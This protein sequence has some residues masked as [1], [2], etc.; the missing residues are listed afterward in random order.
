MEPCVGRGDPDAPLLQPR[1]T[2]GQCGT[3]LMERCVKVAAPY[4]VLSNAKEPRKHARLFYANGY[5]V[6]RLYK[7]YSG[8]KCQ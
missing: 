2:I 6:S 4:G 3:D 5:C 8:T 1:C 7:F